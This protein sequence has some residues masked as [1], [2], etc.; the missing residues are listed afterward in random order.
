MRKLGTPHKNIGCYRTGASRL[1]NWNEYEYW[2]DLVRTKHPKW[3]GSIFVKPSCISIKTWD[4][5]DYLF[6]K[7]VITKLTDREITRAI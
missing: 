2:E 1:P 3:A 7:A 5:A 4:Y 6:A